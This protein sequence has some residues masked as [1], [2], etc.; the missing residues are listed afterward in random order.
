MLRLDQQQMPF[1]GDV[2][3]KHEAL[4]IGSSRIKASFLIIC[5]TPIKAPCVAFVIPIDPFMR[6]VAKLLQK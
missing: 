3:F 4:E 5:Q 1:N 2:Y 6:F